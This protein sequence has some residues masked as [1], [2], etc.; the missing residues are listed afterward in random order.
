MDIGKYTELSQKLIDHYISINDYKMAFT[1]L[2]NYV[3]NIKYAS[4][5]LGILYIRSNR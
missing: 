3:S 2:V 4:R 1:L 5:W